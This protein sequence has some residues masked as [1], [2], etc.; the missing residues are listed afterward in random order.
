MMRARIDKTREKIRAGRLPQTTDAKPAIEA[1]DGN[2]C[3]GCGEII[4]HTEQLYRP[5][6]AALRMHDVCYYAW[7]ALQP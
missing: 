6:G 7:G 1:G 5:R 2:L 4:V 3:S